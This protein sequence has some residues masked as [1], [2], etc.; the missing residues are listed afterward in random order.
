VE[1]VLEGLGPRA[2]PLPL[3]LRASPLSLL[4]EEAEAAVWASGASSLPKGI[5]AANAAVAAAIEAVDTTL[6]F[7]SSA[8]ALPAADFGHA[9][10]GGVPGSLYEDRSD[11]LR[12][13]VL[14]LFPGK[15]SWVDDGALAVARQ[16]LAAMALPAW[17]GEEHRLAVSRLLGRGAGSGRVLTAQH[18]FPAVDEGAGVLV[19]GYAQ[20]LR[21]EP[22]SFVARGF[23]ERLKHAM[24][25]TLA[26]GG[27]DGDAMEQDNDYDYGDNDGEGEE[28]EWGD[29][30]LLGTA[31]RG[32]LLGLL[33]ERASALGPDPPVSLLLPRLVDV[34]AGS[35]SGS[36]GA[37]VVK[38]SKRQRRD[39]V[40]AVQPTAAAGG[41]RSKRVRLDLGGSSPL[42][43]SSPLPAAPAPAPAPA[44]LSVAAAGRGHQR[45]IPQPAPSLRELREAAD[46]ETQQ[47]AR[48]H[49]L[50]DRA[51]AR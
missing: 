10:A 48:L 12:S 13:N 19:D 45:R 34:S 51:L 15:S 11:G 42:P 24:A 37:V 18:A 35:E 32:A 6:R 26:I 40:A 33:K 2:V 5:A 41:A 39:I 27:G 36:Q 21:S 46:D 7:S 49:A 14:P 23:P 50:L 44:L 22:W 3:V 28:E 25:L 17:G 29:L 4:L 9:A 16:Q 31:W 47:V 8:G 43:T 20:A 1:T 30:S 38:Q